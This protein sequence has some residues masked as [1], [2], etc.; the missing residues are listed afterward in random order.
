MDCDGCG[1]VGR[2]RNG[3]ALVHLNVDCWN[4]RKLN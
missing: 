3:R 4:G 1:G 2:E